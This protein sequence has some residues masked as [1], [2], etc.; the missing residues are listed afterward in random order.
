MNTYPD[1]PYTE[2]NFYTCSALLV[3]YFGCIVYNYKF[4]L[5]EFSVF[6]F[7][8]KR[9]KMV[10][11]L[12]IG[13]F[14]VSFCLDGDFFRLMEVIQN[15]D[16]TIG[17]YNYGERVY[18]II[19]S[20]VNRSY[21]LFRLIVWGGAFLLFCITSKRYGI[22][23][24]KASVYLFATMPVTFCYA[25]VTLCMAIVFCG[26]SYFCK[27]AKSKWLGYIIGLLLLGISTYFH[28]SSY[29]MIAMSLAI[30]VPINK[31]TLI[32][33]IILAPIIVRYAQSLFLDLVSV[34]DTFDNEGLADRLNRS[35]E[36][37]GSSLIDFSTPGVAFQRILQYVSFYVPIFT[38]S[39][40]CLKKE[41]MSAIDK[42][43]QR[44]FKV[45]LALFLLSTI[46]LMFEQASNT[47]FYRTLFMTMIPLVIIIQYLRSNMFMSSKQYKMCLD[48]GI[49]YTSIRILYCFYGY[50]I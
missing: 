36:T 11:L 20:V 34:S 8:S 50:G 18:G 37:T 49:L 17:S 21:L 38:V 24:Y 3:M 1:F 28:N 33:L 6:S 25:R 23:V 27:P 15:Y 5:N 30:F 4:A 7:V 12:I 35:V 32:F 16:F 2:P 43:V 47:L 31:K 48:S 46:F 10:Q 22:D 9:T 19:A 39:S 29:I 26:L 14:L 44:M 40:V 13:L 42:G 45:M 41:Y